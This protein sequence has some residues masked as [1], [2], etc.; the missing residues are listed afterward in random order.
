MKTKFFF[1]LLWM[2][3]F[4]YWTYWLLFGELGLVDRLYVK[5]LLNLVIIF[6]FVLHI[7]SPCAILLVNVMVSISFGEVI[8]W[9]KCGRSGFTTFHFI[10]IEL[11]RLFWCGMSR[12]KR[13]KLSFKMS[14]LQPWYIPQKVWQSWIPSHGWW[15]QISRES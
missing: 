15:I 14:N 3:E 2:R 1:G 8:I 12:W 5:M 4:R 9:L 11:F 7:W 6:L 13:T 10:N